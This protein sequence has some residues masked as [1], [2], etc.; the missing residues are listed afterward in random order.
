[1]S[2]QGVG[3]AYVRGAWGWA[4]SPSTWTQGKFAFESA[5]A[6]ACIGEFSVA[7]C[8]ELSEFELGGHGVILGWLMTHGMTEQTAYS[9]AACVGARD[10]FPAN[11]EPEPE[12]G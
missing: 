8:E 4:P 7:S 5:D 1:M 12:V 2:R 6:F 10:S 9:R 11:A 3:L